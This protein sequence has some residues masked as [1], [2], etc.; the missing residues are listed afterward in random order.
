MAG[1]LKA[2][3]MPE[4]AVAAEHNPLGKLLVEDA[5]HGH[6]ARRAHFLGAAVSD[7]VGSGVR[8][9]GSGIEEGKTNGSFVHFHR[10]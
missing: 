5:I 3:G 9:V 4:R 2:L 7:P 1:L 8:P 6:R 10:R